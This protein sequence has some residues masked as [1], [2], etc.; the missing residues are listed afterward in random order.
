MDNKQLKNAYF[1]AC[2]SKNGFVSYFEEIFFSSPQRTVYILKGGPGTGKSYFMKRF[3]EA[4]EKKGFTPEYF[5]CSSDSDSL[6]GVR[7]P[8]L[9]ISVIDGTAPHSADP[10]YP[11]ATETIINLGEFFDVEQLQEHRAKILALN[12][13]KSKYYKTAYAYLH[14]CGILYDI[15]LNGVKPAILMDKLNLSA[16]REALHY[17][18]K[19]PEC[20]VQK[21]FIHALGVKG[22]VCTDAQMHAR[23]RVAISDCLG[24]GHIYIRAL[25]TELKK[26]VAHITVFPDPL[27][28]DKYN[29]LYLP[30]QDVSYTV[31]SSPDER[32][33][34]IINQ[35]RFIDKKMI[36]ADS[37]KLKF[38]KKSAD[39][40]K[41]E[42]LFNLKK[43]GETHSKLEK[44]YTA[45]LDIE[46]KEAFTD[47]FLADIFKS[48]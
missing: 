32:F 38:A 35:R 31:I 9:D 33:G 10:Q 47:A 7:F 12:A 39:S 16:K 36:D 20:T 3:A 34:R 45:A 25:L 6:D 24:T 8:E 37:A 18:S 5:L 48:Y 46:Y 2:N 1:A 41:D 40:L 42:A 27:S 14:A 23:E 17:C 22:E 21:R 4:G 26:R 11:G 28:P 19:A 44:I 13:Q 15:H 43:A 30:D 29:G